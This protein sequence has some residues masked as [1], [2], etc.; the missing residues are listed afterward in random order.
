MDIDPIFVLQITGVATVA[1]LAGRASG[2][3]RI[4][5][6]EPVGSVEKAELRRRLKAVPKAKATRKPGRPKTVKSKDDFPEIPASL[7]RG[8]T[9]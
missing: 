7:R 8:D 1:A 9:P 2:L 5:K 3:F 4:V 6:R